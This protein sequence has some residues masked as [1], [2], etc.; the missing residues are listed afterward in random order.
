MGVSF[1]SK[2]NTKVLRN[3][4]DRSLSQNVMSPLQE[5]RHSLQDHEDSEDGDGGQ[6]DSLGGLL[7]QIQSSV[8]R[9]TQRI[10]VRA[11]DPIPL[12]QEEYYVDPRDTVD[13]ISA[14]K[15]YLQ[16][17]KWDIKFSGVEG[18]SISTFL[19][20][21]QDKAEARG[22]EL[23]ELL[24]YLPELLSGEALSWF[25]VNKSTLQ[26]WKLFS[27]KLSDAFQLTGYQFLV[28]R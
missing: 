23:S 4:L 24:R 12:R 5:S 14:C 19:E 11:G 3:K 27:E 28:K 10:R 9:H 20:A 13:R 22:L 2:A 21:V 17:F 1:N 6:D 16:P 8:G 25:R 15:N 26:T 18:E 7:D